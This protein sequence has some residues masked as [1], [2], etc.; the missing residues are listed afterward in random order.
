MANEVTLKG[1]SANSFIARLLV[2]EHGDGAR[3]RCSG[4]M[5]ADVNAVLLRR[6]NEHS[7]GEVQ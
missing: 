4:P 7:T 1:G 6:A 3:D 2:D 5:L